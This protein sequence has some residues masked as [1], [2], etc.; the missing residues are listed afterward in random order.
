MR[1][2]SAEKLG[3]IHCAPY[4]VIQLRRK[5][6]EDIGQIAIDDLALKA[7]GGEKKGM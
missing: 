3:C 7:G 6:T 5:E 2:M 4:F 1:R